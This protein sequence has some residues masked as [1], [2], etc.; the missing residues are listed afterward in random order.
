MRNALIS[1]ALLSLVGGFSG[2]A[3]VDPRPEVGAPGGGVT[4]ATV[5]RA[6]VQNPDSVD[7]GGDIQTVENYDLDASAA[8]V[9]N[10]ISGADTARDQEID[11]IVNTITKEDEPV[12][13]PISN[14]AVRPAMAPAAP[15][16][17]SMHRPAVPPLPKAGGSASAASGVS[18][19]ISHQRAQPGLPPLPLQTASGPTPE[20]QEMA[21]RQEA[22]FPKPLWRRLHDEKAMG[23]PP[24]APMPRGF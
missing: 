5:K 16:A 20:Q 3:S 18:A 22:L 14:S 11:A 10:T 12:A 2:C 1:L 6:A 23:S 13:T 9:S 24:Q 19:A 8:G 21:A 15:V 17:P 4:G 7:F